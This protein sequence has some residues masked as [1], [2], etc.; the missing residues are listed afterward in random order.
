MIFNNLQYYKEGDYNTEVAH[1]G[2]RTRTI[3]NICDKDREVVGSR[4]NIAFVSINL[5]KIAIQ[6]KGDTTKF[7]DKF[8]KVIELYINLKNYFNN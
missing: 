3:G 4:G 8:T 1:M 7:F 6:S 2:C 5:P